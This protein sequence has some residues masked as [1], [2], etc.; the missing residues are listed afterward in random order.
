[1]NRR[2][3]L[4]RTGGLA[5]LAGLAGCLGTTS[6][7]PP[8][9][10]AETDETTTGA[11]D[12]STTTERFSG[13]RSDHGEPFRTISVGSRDA[14]AFPD[15]NRPREIRVWNAADE[16]R[17][18]DLQISRDAE[19][20]VDRTVEFAADA[21]LEVALNEP[22]DHS[23]SVGLA[24]G[25][26]TT[27]GVERTS[28]DCNSAGTDVGVMPDGRVETMSMSTAMGCPR[29]KVAGTDLSVGQGT[30]GKEH[31]AS[32]AF[33]DEAV[34]VDGTVRT[35]TPD[36]G[37][38]LADAAYD[39]ETGALTLRVRATGSDNDGGGVGVQCVGEVPYEA[40]IGFDHGWSS[41]VVVVHDSMD[42]TTEVTRVERGSA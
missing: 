28:F 2:A 1:M 10:D 41:S 33:E 13:V 37:L 15:N 31:S 5:T 22:A 27:F 20:L 3:F 6:D 26:A 36:S 14:V 42:E 9:D 17:D 29:P 39:A 23:V 24:D 8:G 38:E 34:R 7:S 35:P 19:I 25:N 40:T 4:Q 30:C 16:A 21:Y 32:V 18:I 12:D 11:A